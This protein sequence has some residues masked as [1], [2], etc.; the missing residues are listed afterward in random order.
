MFFM[1]NTYYSLKCV[2]GGL[3]Q[4]GELVSNKM[5]SEIFIL[6]QFFGDEAVF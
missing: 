2:W 6:D 3:P 5:Q 4:L 1:L